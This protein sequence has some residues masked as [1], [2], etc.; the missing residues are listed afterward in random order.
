MLRHERMRRVALK[1]HAIALFFF[2]LIATCNLR[3][4]TC[5]LARANCRF[6]TTERISHR[7]RTM[8]MELDQVGMFLVSLHRLREAKSKGLNCPSVLFRFSIF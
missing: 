3:L 2:L 7:W 4:V 6:V 1:G 8:V 5:E